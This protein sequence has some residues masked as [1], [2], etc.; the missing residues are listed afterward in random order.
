V[1]ALVQLAM[2]V[3]G[4]SAVYGAVKWLMVALGVVL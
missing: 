2:A 4:M 3:A 1:S